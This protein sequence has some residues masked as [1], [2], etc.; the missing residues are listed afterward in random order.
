[1]HFC[2]ACDISDSVYAER[3]RYFDDCSWS[4]LVLVAGIEVPA[5][6][7]YLSEGGIPF[8]AQDVLDR[9]DYLVNELRLNGS[10]VSTF[11]HTPKTYFNILA[12]QDERTRELVIIIISDTA[13]VAMKGPM[14]ASLDFWKDATVYDSEK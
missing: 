9:L 10:I 11:D 14:E 3:D 6:T 8:E 2:Q 1:M 13:K 7:M 12:Q 4:S 5:Q